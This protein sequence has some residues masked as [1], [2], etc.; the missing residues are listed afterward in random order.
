MATMFLSEGTAICINVLK[1]RSWG[2]NFTLLLRIM[3]TL[4][5]ERNCVAFI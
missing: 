5:K 3:L 1:E 4:L 2:T